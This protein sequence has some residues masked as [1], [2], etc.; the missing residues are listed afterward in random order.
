MDYIDLRSDT[1]TRPTPEMREAMYRAEVGD[2]V[3][4]D[5][6]TVNRLQEI[7]ADLTGH[8]D[9]LFVA[10]GTMGNLVGIL[11]HCG[12]GDEAILGA[13]SHSVLY[14]GG[15][16]S[17]LGGVHSRQV[18]EQPDGSLALGDVELLIRDDDEHYPVSKL[19]GIENTHNRCGGTYQSPDYIRSL[20]DFA[21][22]RGLVVHMDGARVF[23]AAAALG[24]EARKITQAVDSITFC[25]SKGLCAPVGSILCGS[26]EFIKTARRVRKHV[27]GGMRQAGVIAAAGIIALQKMTIRLGEDHARARELAEALSDIPGIRLDG[28]SPATNMIYFNLVDGANLTA[29]QLETAMLEVGVLIHSVNERRIRVVTHYWID[30]SAVERAAASFR[31][32]LSPS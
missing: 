4:G 5:D 28:G 17:A 9:A 14:E 30:D 18:L 19:I 1:V 23:N 2:D 3:F 21:H 26:R 25:L 11:S 31:E 27:G 12:R 15:G 22:A 32:V 16:I 6:P 13:R 20:A 10:S 24:V 29:S 8:E 7:A